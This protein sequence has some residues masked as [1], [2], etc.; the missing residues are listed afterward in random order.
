MA[1]RETSL[2]ATPRLLVAASICVVVAALYF[3]RDMLMPLAVAT[4]ITFVLTPLVKRLEQWRVG[5]GLA[6]CIVVSFSLAVGGGLGYVVWRQLAAVVVDELP[7]LRENIPGKLAALRESV[8]PINRMTGEIEQAV[9][10][11]TSQP[12]TTQSTRPSPA[13]ATPIAQLA[14]DGSTGTSDASPA[15][16]LTRAVEAPLAPP[17]DES[18]IPVRVVNLVHSPLDLVAQYFNVILSPLAT[19]L[20]VA[21]LVIFM[22]FGREDLRDRLI[23]LFGGGRLNLTTQAIDE[24]THRITRYLVAQSLVNT[25]YGIAVMVGLWLIGR[26]FSEHGFPNVLLW[27]LLCGLLRFIPYVGIWIAMALPLA[28]SFALFPS[29]AVFFSTTSMFVGY[30]LIVSQFF[31]PYFYGS[32]TGM[33]ALAVLIAAIFWTA[34]W[35]PM[36]LL[37]STPMTVCL[38]VLGKYV[39]QLEFLNILLGDEPVLQPPVRLYQR[40]IALDQEEAA[41]LVQEYLK[42]ASPEQLY[43]QVLIPALAMAERDHHHGELDDERRE[44]VLHGIR[45]LIE[46]LDEQE[47]R[48][49]EKVPP[50]TTPPRWTLPAD[51]TVNVLCLAARDRADELAAMML[52]GLLKQRGYSAE[53]VGSDVLAGEM[54]ALVEQKKADIV[55]LSALPPAAIAHARYVAKRLHVQSPELPT[56]VGLWT[57]AGDLE[58]ARQRIASQE[59]MQ[60]VTT[61]AEAQTHIDQIAHQV[62]AAAA[63]TSASATAK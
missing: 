35:G 1:R 5:R 43:D 24:A 3:G 10:A 8:S 55:C 41:D 33:S 26:V 16:S 52:A 56:I 32:S 23:R 63:S 6:V 36:G 28:V 62:I 61:L 46:E 31:E 22:L 47:P 53:A 12:A 50:A 45:E 57:A 13:V 39:P 60:L 54:T 7:Q 2:S 18:A 30:E 58:R 48:G 44:L 15:P 14:P 19:A 38:I 59:S 11:P 40:L 21:V 29:N 49:A 17:S 27:A 25:C 4:L 51:A 42:T 34:L 37:L 9:K 20:I